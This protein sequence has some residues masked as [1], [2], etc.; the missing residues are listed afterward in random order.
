MDGDG[1]NNKSSMF[2]IS[3]KICKILE[4]LGKQ[5]TFQEC[6]K[7]HYGGTKFSLNSKLDI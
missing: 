6:D 5:D 7:N 1:L 3:C 4:K 2:F